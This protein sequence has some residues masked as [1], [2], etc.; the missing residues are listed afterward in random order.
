M[1]A[2]AFRSGFLLCCLALAAGCSSTTFFYNRLD[3]IL[4]WYI[5]DYANLNRQQKRH[6]D[7]LLDPFLQWHRT[8]ELP[9]YLLVLDEVE[10]TL[11]RELTAQDIAA[12]SLEF[13]KAWQRVEAEALGWAIE[14]G[15]RLSDE[16]MTEFLAELEERQRELREEYLE[17]DDAE[18]AEDSYDRMADTA[19]DYLGRL[20]P[21]QRGILRTSSERLR[22]IDADWL[23]QRRVFLDRLAV[24]LEREPGWQS[25]LRALVAARDEQLSPGYVAALDHNLA[26]LQETAA[27][28]LNAR[29]ERQDRHLRRRLSGVRGDVRKLVA[30]AEEGVETGCRAAPVSV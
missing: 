24:V 5:D 12:L 16:Q 21:E 13:E 7:E 25:R 11:D 17:R 18:V 20:Q 9:C 14:L 27:K 28:V 1:A 15:E 4:P 29:S 23:A 26:L 6:L 30:Q 10:T 8:R 19:E 2:R 22:R 3:F